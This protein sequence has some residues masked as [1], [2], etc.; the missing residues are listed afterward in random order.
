MDA[1]QKID[2]S[3]SLNP[4]DVPVQQKQNT[5]N[6]RSIFMPQ[7]T[8]KVELPF[9]LRRTELVRPNI[10]RAMTQVQKN[11]TDKLKEQRHQA[12]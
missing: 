4:P 10:T 6:K 8:L 3:I 9:Q 12:L 2:E 7:S 11:S 1:S 5:F